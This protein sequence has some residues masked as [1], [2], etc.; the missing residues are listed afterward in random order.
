[1]K[2]EYIE[3]KEVIESLKIFAN[4]NCS[5]DIGKNI[6]KILNYAE[7]KLNLDIESDKIRLNKLITQKGNSPKV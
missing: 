2:R 3:L 5:T 6:S 4:I 7:I 1:M